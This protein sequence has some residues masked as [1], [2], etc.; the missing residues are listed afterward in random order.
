MALAEHQ[1]PHLVLLVLLV[2]LSS[3]S[4]ATSISLRAVLA[5]QEATLVL[6][7]RDSVAL[8]FTQQALMKHHV[9]PQTGMCEPSLAPLVPA[10]L[11]GDDEL[12]RLVGRGP[13]RVRQHVLMQEQAVG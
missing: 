8:L 11:A 3:A 10:R 13:E 1:H 9:R 12:R 5:G 7:G 6:L 2:L 4:T